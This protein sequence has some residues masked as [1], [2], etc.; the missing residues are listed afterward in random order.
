MQMCYLAGAIDMVIPEQ[1]RGWR[2]NVSKVL[3]DHGIHTFDPASAF[4]LSRKDSET[5]LSKTDMVIKLNNMALDSSEIMLAEME[6]NCQHTGTTRELIRAS[7]Q[8]GKL[9]VVWNSSEYT[10]LYLTDIPNLVIKSTLAECVEYIIEKITGVAPSPDVCR[11]VLETKV[12]KPAIKVMLTEKH[13]LMIAKERGEISDIDPSMLLFKKHSDDTG[14]DIM[15]TENVT[16]PPG[17]KVQVPTHLAI[18]PPKGYWYRLVAR[19]STFHVHEMLVVEG[20]IDTQFRG[21]LYC[22]I[23]NMS[24]ETKTIRAGDSVAQLIFHEIVGEHWDVSV[25]DSLD[26]TDRG[27]GGFGSTTASK[28]FI[29]EMYQ[30]YASV[31]V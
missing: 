3:N 14:Y 18:Q 8:D 21:V 12:D 15:C 2:D 10:P 25:H 1:A 13:P 29:V 4:N 22:N 19:S 7:E 11:S 23:Q 27:E 30:K 5:W 9:V 17:G 16:V 26:A 24:N 20:I 6:F 28:D 31:T